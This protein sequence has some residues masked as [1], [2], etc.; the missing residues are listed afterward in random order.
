MESQPSCLSPETADCLIKTR[1]G[2]VSVF[3]IVIPNDEVPNMRTGLAKD[4]G[5]SVQVGCLLFQVLAPTSD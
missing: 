4:D 5:L 3:L 1:L 2:Q